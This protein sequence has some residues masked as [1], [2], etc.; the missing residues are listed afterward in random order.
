MID[1]ASQ[2]VWPLKNNLRTNQKETKG[3]RG[4]QPLQAR[5][6]R[7]TM[8][9]IQKWSPG[10]RALLGSEGT[11]RKILYG[12]YGPRNTK[13]IPKAPGRMQRI[14][15]WTL[16]RGQPPPKWKKRNGSHGRNRW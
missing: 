2:R 14:M 8:D 11:L 4:K 3:Q 15:E 7:T 12:I 10:E 5:K 13:K 6:K 9:G 1:Q 16:W